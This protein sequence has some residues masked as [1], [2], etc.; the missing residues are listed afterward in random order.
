MKTESTALPKTYR[1][2]LQ[3]CIGLKKP[4]PVLAAIPAY[5]F[6]TMTE[7]MPKREAMK[8]IRKLQKHNP[9][10]LFLLEAA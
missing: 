4:I 7:A 2:T 8:H 1:V 6:G 5:I 10:Y 3:I 9:G